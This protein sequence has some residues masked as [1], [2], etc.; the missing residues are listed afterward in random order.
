M[1]PPLHSGVKSALSWVDSS[2]WKPSKATKDANIRRQGFGLRILRCVKYF[3]HRYLEKGRTI[4]SEYYIALLMS[5]KEEL[6]KK[7]KKKKRPKMKKK[8]C[9]FKTI[10][11]VTSRSQRWQKFMNCTSNCFRTPL[12]SI[13]G[14]RD[15]WLFA[16][17][18][19]M[20]Q[21]KRFG[22][23][24]VISETEAYFEAKDKSFHKKGIELLEKR[25]N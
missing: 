10:Y 16:D 6:A 11:R 17:L 3:V 25:W 8:K 19:R 12:F 20:L 18:K 1:D 22:S 9:S 4:N 13:S 24:E 21:R 7:K 2:K 23:N 5:L 15:Y 14:P